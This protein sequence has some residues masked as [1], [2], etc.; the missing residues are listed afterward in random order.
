METF[1][2]YQ[3]QGNRAELRSKEKSVALRKKCLYS[4]FSWSVFSSIRNEYGNLKNKS[5]YSLL[6]WGNTDQKTGPIT[7]FFYAVVW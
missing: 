6:M 4:D 2:T 1:V 3:N 7:G 5:P